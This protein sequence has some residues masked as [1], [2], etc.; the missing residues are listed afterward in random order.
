MEKAIKIK[1]IKK[2]GIC[3][4]IQKNKIS[5]K[6]I[7]ILLSS[8]F[9]NIFLYKDLFINNHK[10]KCLLSLRPL[11]SFCIIIVFG[12]R[13]DVLK[14]IPIIKELKSNKKFFCITINTGQH[15]K[16][17]NKILESLNMAK[18]VDIEL[19]VMRKNQTLSKLTSRIILELDKIYSLFNP[20]SVIVQGDTTT[21]FAA[22]LSAFYKKIPIFHVES[23][24][25]TKNI[26]SPF[27]EEFNRI[28][29]DDI[30]T[31]LFAPTYISAINL[32]KEEKNINKIF[33]T[34]N[35]I[36]DTLKLTLNKT[37][38]SKYIDDLIQNAKSFCKNIIECK[39]IL[40]TC[41]RRE[42]YFHPILNIIMAAQKLLKD[43]E[44][45]VIIFPFHLNP[46]VIQSIKMG[47]P[48]EIYN[49]LINRKVIKD[50]SFSHFNR[51]FLIEPLNYIDN[52]HL[53]SISF[54]IMTDSGGIQEESISIGKP[55]LIL[56]TN[57]ERI[58]G[59][60]L[61]CAIL[62][63]ISFENIYNNASLLLKNKT[64]YN[65]MSKPHK[66]VYGSGNSSKIIVNLIESYFENGLPESDYS[67]LKYY[68]VL[69][70]LNYSEILFKYDNLLSKS[71]NEIQYDIIIVLTVWKRNN[72]ESQLIQIKRQSIIDPK[73]NKKINIIIFQNSNHTDITDI[74]KKWNMP[75]IFNDNV[76]ITF[77]NSQFETGYFGRFLSP[78]TSP[79]TANAYF[80]ICDDDII[81]GDRYFENM[82]RV[83]DE[84]FLATR[85]GRLIDRNYVEISPANIA[86]RKR[87]QACYNEDIEY[88][89]GGH[90][91]AG[92]IS[93]LRKAWTHIPV[94][95]ENSEDFW[96]S[97]V[98]KSFYNIS[99][100]SPKCP[101]PE[102][103]KVINPDFCA[104]SHKNA[105]YHSK[106]VVGKKY[107]TEPNL[108]NKIMKLTAEKFNYKPLLSQD[109]NLTEKIKKKFKLGDD[110]NPLFNL[111]DHLW[112]N[113]LFWQ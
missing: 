19:N 25:R 55:V 90:I 9:L 103:G 27:P 107:F 23:G 92:R 77:I 33:V 86:W 66:N 7:L 35:T 49:D 67:N 82:I 50:P 112:D 38:P 87:V 3:K 113:I 94:S 53:L 43:F 32:L 93:W 40:L 88:D 57:T 13:P 14:M 96:I 4:R 30:S 100:R 65:E 6:K 59:V 84:G 74:I 39:I 29:I 21:S 99:T 73:T 98:L 78:L 80:I 22:A 24:L 52:I 34:G 44:N 89:F 85:N 91:W 83:V 109:P 81:W 41:H 70:E 62:T 2:I 79:V 51:L 48:E 45:I 102:G 20:K 42:N 5:I 75:N 64:L 37:N 71:N 11:N 105:G 68:K 61:G 28:A 58:E 47:I 26:S 17:A 101:C 110:K 15:Q 76:K 31:L 56:R 63:G 72:L 36:V 69:N 95:I 106:S 8:F 16:M 111:S 1:R 97:S 54:F 12:T 46:N 60:K 108:R 18:Y 104:A 10:Y